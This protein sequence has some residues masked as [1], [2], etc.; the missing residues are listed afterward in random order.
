[1]LRNNLSQLAASYHSV[2][3]LRPEATALM[4]GNNPEITSFII[5][6]I[7]IFV[8]ILY[9][10]HLFLYVYDPHSFLSFLYSFFLGPRHQ[11]LDSLQQRLLL[12]ASKLRLCDTKLQIGTG[13]GNRNRLPLLIL[14]SVFWPFLLMKRNK[15]QTTLFAVASL[16]LHLFS[17][18]YNR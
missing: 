13:Q 16:S 11:L 17:V 10:F 3:V 4:K 1:M 7:C 8:R 2:S 6:L 12:L 18:S 9:N 15:P 5:P 14:L